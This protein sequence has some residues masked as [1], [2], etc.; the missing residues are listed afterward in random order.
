MKD[1]KILDHVYL[2]KKRITG[3]VIDETVSRINGRIYY[4]V[5]ADDEF[6][7][8]DPDAYPTPHPLYDCL[9]EDLEVL[10]D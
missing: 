7:T 1:I 10:T 3:I 6:E 8:N 9:V 2:K 4:I 5:E